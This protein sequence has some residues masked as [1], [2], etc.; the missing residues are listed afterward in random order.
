MLIWLAS[1][2]RSG[3]TLLRK[4]LVYCFGAVSRCIYTGIRD[5]DQ[6]VIAAGA[7]LKPGLDLAKTH[8]FPSDTERAIYV[9]RDGRASVVSFQHFHRDIGG[10]EV[11]LTDIIEGKVWPG[12][13]SDHV[14]QWALSG[15]EN[16]LV[17]R[18]EKLSQGDQETLDQISEFTGLPQV[19]PYNLTLDG[20]RATA[21]NPKQ[22]RIGRNEPA[23]EQIEREHSTL[24]WQHH[25]DAMMRLGYA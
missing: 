7:T 21:R 25:R 1:Y 5:D 17:I 12:S 13:W 24:F 9:V 23:I 3:N 15:R 6:D 22:F 19:R 8:E 11:A 18:F 16:T 14:S 4:T 10:K 20:L 2:P